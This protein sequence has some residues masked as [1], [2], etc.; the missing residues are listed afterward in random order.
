M[1]DG[2]VGVGSQLSQH[3]LGS[4]DI[5]GLNILAQQGQ[6]DQLVNHLNLQ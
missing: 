4:V 5:P 1:L 6:Y 2:T 3:A